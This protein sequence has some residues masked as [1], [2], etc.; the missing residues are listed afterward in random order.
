MNSFQTSFIALIFL[1]AAGFSAHSQTPAEKPS[2]P[3]KAVAVLHP[4]PGSKVGGTVISQPG[5]AGGN[6]VILCRRER[7]SDALEVLRSHGVSGAVAAEPVDYVFGDVN[8]LMQTLR[9]RLKT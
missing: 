2:A 5:K 1:L 9:A 8:P 7:L 3:L 6:H 4:T